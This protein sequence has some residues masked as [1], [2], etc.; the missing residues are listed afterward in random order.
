MKNLFKGNKGKPKQTS[1][2]DWE[3]RQMT[4]KTIKAF[5]EKEFV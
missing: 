4:F 3:S 2:E 1:S 5:K